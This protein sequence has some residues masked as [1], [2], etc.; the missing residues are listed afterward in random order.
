MDQ[1][2][3]LTSETDQEAQPITALTTEKLIKAELPTDLQDYSEDNYFTAEWKRN[4][5]TSTMKKPRP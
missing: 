3:D 2:P 5:E 4:T 1:Q